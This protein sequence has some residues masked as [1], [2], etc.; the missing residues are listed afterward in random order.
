M[1][2]MEESVLHNRS[3]IQG[4]IYKIEQYRKEL[5]SMHEDVRL[6]LEDKIRYAYPQF[7]KLIDEIYRFEREIHS[8]NNNDVQFRLEGLLDSLM[9]HK[10]L[11]ERMFAGD[12]QK[13]KTEAEEHDRFLNAAYRASADIWKRQGVDPTESK[14]YL[15]ERLLPEY[16]NAKKHL[17]ETQKIVFAYDKDQQRINIKVKDNE[18]V[19]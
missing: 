7:E 2:G 17:G 12:E 11:W 6:Y 19:I 8:F 1:G 18:T 15:T 5:N 9:I 14:A 10:R 4:L 16:V 13:I 3:R